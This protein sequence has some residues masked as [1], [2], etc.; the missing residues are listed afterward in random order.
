MLVLFVLCKMECMGV[1]ID[2]VCLYVQ[3]IEIV[4]CLIE[5]EGQ[6]YELVG[7][8]FNFGLLKQIG[9]IFFEKL[10]LL[11]VKKMLSGVLLIDEEVLQKL[12]EDYLLLKLLFEYCG[13]LKLKLI[14]IDKF[15]CMVNF[16]IGC[17]Y[18]NYVQ[19]V[20]VMGCLVLNDFN[21]QNILVCMVEGWCICE[22]FI[23]VLGYWIVL[24]DYLQ[25]ELWIMVYIF[26]DVLL[27]CVF[28]QGED[29][30]CVMVVEVFGVMLL[31]VNFD[32]CWI[33]KVI[34]FGFIYGMSVFGFVLNFGIMCDV[35][36]FY[37]DCYF[38]CYLG[39]VQYMEDMCVIVKEK[40]YVEIVFGCCLWLFEINGGNGLCCQVVECVVINVLMQGMVV[41][42]IKL[43][44]I[45]VD[46]WFMCDWFVLWMIM[47]VY[48][49]LVFEVLEGEL[50][51]VCE[52]LL[53]MM[54]GVVKLKVLLVVEVGVG[55]NWEEVY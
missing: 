19:V 33:V 2:D 23:V 3:S 50:L 48:D 18:M 12:V 28:L 26:G 45:V 6:V 30:Y 49:E 39:V 27:L 42:L 43:L 15:L 22:V 16:I 52:K 1:L 10:Q 41:D 47:Q 36:K 20:V 25:I 7:G 44:M 31:E 34:N 21:F 11:V 40:G 5:F 14:Y 24:V 4:M 32:Q 17:V 37:I 35:V 8:E 53:E 51:F 55:V 46:D 38:V 13:L 29:I 9:Q 54:C